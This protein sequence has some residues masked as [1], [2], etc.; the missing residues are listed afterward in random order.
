MVLKQ[1]C[2]G[3]VLLYY[4]VTEIIL[5]KKPQVS[6]FQFGDPTSETRSTTLFVRTV[7]YHLW[8]IAGKSP[9]NHRT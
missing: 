2:D 5:T 4:Y 7:I 6:Q 3:F 9:K 8:L 1:I